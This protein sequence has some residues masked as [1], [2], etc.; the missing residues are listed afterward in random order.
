MKDYTEW[1]ERYIKYIVVLIFLLLSGHLMA[2]SFASKLKYSTQEVAELLGDE[3]EVLSL[4]IAGSSFAPLSGGEVTFLSGCLVNRPLPPNGADNDLG[5]Y[6]NVNLPANATV[7]GASALFFD[8]APADRGR[9]S[10]ILRTHDGMG[11]LTQLA[12]AQRS[13]TAHFPGFY[14]QLAMV[15]PPYVV[16]DNDFF[17]ALFMPGDGNGIINAYFICGMQVF[18][19]LNQ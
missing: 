1:H 11:N 17:D 9:P 8:V 10:L 19:Q 16:N 5:M 18:Y 7:V 15:D 13:N 3:G 2:Q 6:A 4:N 14:E 12:T